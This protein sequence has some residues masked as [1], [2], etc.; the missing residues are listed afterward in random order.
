MYV[1]DFISQVS[2]AK[3]TDSNTV[4]SEST[5]GTMVGAA[6]GTGIGLFIGFGRHKNLLMS[7]FIGG[8]IGG[9]ISRAFIVK[10]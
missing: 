10:K 6:I 3:T 8:M 5:K 9:L 2:A 4:L 1:K 7:G